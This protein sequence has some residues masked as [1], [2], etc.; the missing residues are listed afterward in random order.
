MPWQ[1]RCPLL[2]WPRR[3]ERAG[4][5]HL[6]QASSP[7]A[8]RVDRP[9]ALIGTYMKSNK[10]IKERGYAANCYRKVKD[11]KYSKIIAAKALDLDYIALTAGTFGAFG[12]GT[13]EI[14]DRVC[15]PR[16]HPLA[17]GDHDPWRARGPRRDFILT[18]GFA[19]QRGN[20]RMIRECD[21]RRR[22]NRVNN[23]FASN[24]TPSR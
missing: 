15:D 9:Q 14:I 16:S 3:S 6:A 2:G 1:L 24:A 20:T 18:I 11:S 10:S 7:Y 5:L 13:W 12:N 22:S 8:A 17:I 23:R 21:R 19:L 4:G